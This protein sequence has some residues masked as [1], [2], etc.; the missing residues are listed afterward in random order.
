MAGIER[1]YLD[2][3]LFIAAFERK[4]ALGIRFGELFT[5][6]RQ[7]GHKAF[8]TSELTLSEVLVGP[9]RNRDTNLVA[10]YEMLVRT[11][12]WLD[13]IPVAR[14]VLQK[15]ALLRASAL[16]LKLPDAIHLATA[17]GVGCTHILTDD[18]GI[19]Q[20]SLPADAQVAVLRPD[21]ATLDALIQELSA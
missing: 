10:S 18:R 1:I 7:A 6:S 16:S 20:A 9:C 5:A 14:P 8:V 3:N 19:G 15:A 17:L 11:S 13:V 4:D 2:T 12:E 21:A